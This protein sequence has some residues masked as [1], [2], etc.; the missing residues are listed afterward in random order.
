MNERVARFVVEQDGLDDGLQVAADAGAV[1]IEDLRDAVNVIAAGVAG[2]QALN[3][4]A[5][6]ERRDVLVVE[7][8]IEGGFKVLGAIQ[9]EIGAVRIRLA[10]LGRR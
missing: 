3:E 10:A 6:D 8:R 9:V 1:V 4:F 5:A 7:N 2:H